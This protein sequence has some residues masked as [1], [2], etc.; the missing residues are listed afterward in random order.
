MVLFNHGAAEKQYNGIWDTP[1]I[2][3]LA[4]CSV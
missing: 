1:R 2:Y 4:P 3:F